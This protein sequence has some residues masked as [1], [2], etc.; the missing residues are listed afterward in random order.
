MEIPIAEALAKIKP[1]EPFK[2]AYR[3]REEI[4]SDPTP[5]AVHCPDRCLT[6]SVQ[7]K[8]KK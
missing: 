7:E 8:Q 4:E 2:F 5:P 3:Q 6:M 1:T